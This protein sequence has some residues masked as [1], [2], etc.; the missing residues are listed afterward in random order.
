MLN[1]LKKPLIMLLAIS[2]GILIFSQTTF[3][4]RVFLEVGVFEA[5]RS[6]FALN[7][8]LHACDYKD[9]T[10]ILIKPVATGVGEGRYEAGDIVEIR[11]G[12]ALCERFGDKDFLGSSEKTNFLVVYYP[13]KLTEEQ[14][15]ELI[16]SEYATST[17]A[18]GDTTQTMVKRRQ[19]GIDYTKFL[20]GTDVFKVRSSETLDKIPQIDLTPVIK[21]STEQKSVVQIPRHLAEIEN[22]RNT[23]NKIARKIIPFVYAGTGGTK[24]ICTSGCNYTTLNAWEAG[25]EGILT[26]PAIAQITGGFQD[27]TA[28]TINGWTTSATNYIYIYT[29]SAA[30]HSGKWDASKYSLV[31]SVAYSGVIVISD[32]YARIDGLQIEN[33][34]A[35]GDNPLG[36]NV[37]ATATSSSNISISNNIVRASGTG[38]AGTNTIGI[39]PTTGLNLYVWNNISY[40]W[41]YNLGIG[42]ISTAVNVI[43]YNNTL[44]D[45][46][47]AGMYWGFNNAPNV[48]VYNNLVQGSATNYNINFVDASGNNL[49]QDTFSPNADYRS[50]VVT[51]VASSTDDFHL[52]STDTSAKDAGTDLSSDAFLAFSTD[53]DGETRSAPWDIGADEYVAPPPSCGDGT[54]NGSETCVSCSADCG[55]CK[56]VLKNNVI[57]KRNVAFGRPSTPFTT[58]P[59][60]SGNKGNI[61][62]DNLWTDGGERCFITKITGGC[63]ATSISMSAFIKYGGADVPGYNFTY[64]VYSDNAGE[65]NTLLGYKV[66]TTAYSNSLVWHTD[67]IAVATGAT[68]FWIGVCLEAAASPVFSGSS[69]TGGTTKYLA[70]ADHTNPPATWDTVNDHNETEQCSIYITF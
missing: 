55:T 3:G 50:R 4:K 24:T 64:V 43:V 53:I 5:V 58:A 16:R 20:S 37:T 38:T 25:E 39:N 7:P 69:T 62:E 47:V 26:E 19:E 32:P 30:R 59:A 31:V 28:V 33:T 34:R 40:D 51:F 1:K 15:A 12:T 46:V 2:L 6:F 29:T 36:I 35:K 42:Y 57:L 10:I 66:N 65:P 48:R 41:G 68:T 54:C 22:F 27:T 60:C 49:S 18:K 17:N 56:A 63:N 45:G 67:T 14:K 23:I 8:E 9:G 52:A 61:A 44:I 70:L 13:A 11:D 21:K